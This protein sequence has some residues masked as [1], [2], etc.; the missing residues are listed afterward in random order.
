MEL[1]LFLPVRNRFSLKSSAKYA[2]NIHID[3]DLAKGKT[4]RVDF[5]NDALN[6]YLNFYFTKRYG[7]LD[8]RTSLEGLTAM[9]KQDTLNRIES[10]R[11]E[12]ANCA[13]FLSYFKA[14]YYIRDG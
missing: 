2:I 11:I 5:A 3:V 8:K 12:S 6:N 13:L 9:Q 4:R 14:T 10:N 7:V 1:Q